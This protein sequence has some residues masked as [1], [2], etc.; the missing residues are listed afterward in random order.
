M[1]S[2]A[3]GCIAEVTRSRGDSEMLDHV[4]SRA[5]RLSAEALNI[6]L[7]L[8]KAQSAAHINRLQMQ[9]TAVRRKRKK[10]NKLHSLNSRTLENPSK[11][12]WKN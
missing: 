6:A 12:E 1:Q 2:L 4:K 9:T 8:R 7:N 10:N 5:A 11:T 3:D